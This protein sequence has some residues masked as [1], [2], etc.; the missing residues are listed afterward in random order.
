MNGNTD[1]ANSFI[2]IIKNVDVTC[3]QIVTGEDPFPLN[4]P[5]S[6]ILS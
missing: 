5:Y 3:F 2:K 6:P 1:V 4:P